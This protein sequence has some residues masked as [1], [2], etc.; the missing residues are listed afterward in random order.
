ME[1]QGEKFRAI[2]STCRGCEKRYPGCHDHCE[3]YQ[4]AQA[5]WLKF[6]R[7]IKKN[8]RL[9]KEFDSFRIDGTIRSIKN[10]R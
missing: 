9:H 2:K 5:E 10:G 8:K 4:E 1:Y 6:K 7:E 3:S